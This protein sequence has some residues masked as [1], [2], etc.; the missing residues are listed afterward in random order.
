MQVVGVRGSYSFATFK[1]Q[2]YIC[3]SEPEEKVQMRPGSRGQTLS[4]EFA[5]R[6]LRLLAR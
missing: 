6:L 1:T 2:L 5:Q 3:L 4:T